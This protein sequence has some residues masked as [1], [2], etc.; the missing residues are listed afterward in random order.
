MAERPEDEPQEP[1]SPVPEDE[2][3]P[4]PPEPPPLPE[5]DPPGW[6]PPESAPPPVA[7]PRPPPPPTY[8]PPPQAPPPTYPPPPQPGYGPFAPYTAAPLPPRRPR[9]PHGEPVVGRWECATWPSRVGAF[10]IDLLIV[11]VLPLGLGIALVA[12]GGDGAEV[13]GTVVLLA[14]PPL[15]WGLYSAALMARPGRHNG[16]TVGKQALGVRVVRDNDQPI[17]FAYGLLR[18]LAVRQVLLT[19]SSSFVFGIPYLLDSLWPLWDESNRTLHDMIV[20]SHVV[21]EEAVTA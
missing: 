10:L 20:S 1:L 14:G 19:I 5:A 16:Q 21:R 17:G 11:L 13:A 15:V 8:A 9:G 18:E 4:P 12:A 7:S 3:L 2:P 6:L